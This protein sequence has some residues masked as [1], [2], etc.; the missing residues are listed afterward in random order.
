[1]RYLQLEEER[2]RV[3]LGFKANMLADKDFQIQNKWKTKVEI[4]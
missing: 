4:L 3:M 1:M 2:L